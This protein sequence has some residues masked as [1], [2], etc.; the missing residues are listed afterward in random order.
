MLRI[1]F[2]TFLVGFVHIASSAAIFH[3]AMGGADGNPGTELQPFATVARAASAA[4]PGDTVIVHSGSYPERVTTVR[5]GTSDRTRIQF[6][7]DGKAVLRG[8]TIAHS[9]ITL[10]G[11]EFTGHADANRNVGYILVQDNA[12]YCQILNNTVRDGVALSRDDFVFADNAPHNDTITS[13]A[14]GFVQAGFV[15]GMPVTILLPAS[16]VS[17]LNS[18][19][20]VIQSVTDNVITLATNQNLVNQGPVAA[21]LDASVNYGIVAGGTNSIV[22]SN[23]FSNLSYDAAFWGGV[24]NIFEHNIIEQCNGWEAMHFAGRNNIVRRNWIRNSDIQTRSNLSPDVFETF[25]NSPTSDILFDENFVGDFD[26]VLGILRDGTSRTMSNVVFLRNV[27]FKTGYFAV[28]IPNVH[29]INN[30]F[31]RVAEGPTAAYQA[32]FHPV[33]FASAAGQFSADGAVVRNN[34]F[35]SS[36]RQDRFVNIS[37]WYETQA[38]TN[39]VAEGNFV[40]GAG[41]SYLP[42]DGFNEGWPN[43]NGGDPG[44]VNPADLLGPDGLPFTDD[45]GLRLRADSKLLEAGAGGVTL[46]AYDGVIQAAP[47]LFVSGQAGA[48]RISWQENASEGWTLQSST[49]LT[50]GWQNVSEVPISAD[51]TKSAVLTNSHRAQFFRLTR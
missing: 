47:K 21:Y 43:L 48:V 42:K 35:V 16:S 6:K 11:F 27:F 44:F 10:D 34:I 50:G 13:A 28:R 22:R 15:P 51:G 41:P 5:G 45:D 8:F 37:G 49:S 20:R 3:V 17:L 23:R 26:G 33:Q 2:A 1:F 18:G 14:G 12:Q 36:G 4:L 40:S 7:A 30:T 46:G 29:F 9:F 25:G 38:L 24:S 19:T 32:V 31:F 39:F